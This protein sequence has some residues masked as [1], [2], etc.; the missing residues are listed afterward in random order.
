MK[1]GLV[2]VVAVWL[3]VPGAAFAGGPSERGL[4]PPAPVEGPSLPARDL[5]APAL[6]AV[7]AAAIPAAVA[8]PAVPTLEQLGEAI[9]G[10]TPLQGLPEVRAR[11][12]RL[13][14]LRSTDFDHAA[15]EPALRELAQALW[16]EAAPIT[17]RLFPVDRTGPV[18]ALKVEAGGS[19]YYVHGVAHAPSLNLPS[20]RRSEV[21][22]LVSEARRREEPL[23]SEL[24]LPAAYSFDYGTEVVD[25]G[26][27]VSERPAFKDVIVAAVQRAWLG[28]KWAAVAAPA[29][30]V[31][32][33]PSS[34]GAW[35]AL[36]GGAAAAYLIHRSFAPA[37]RAA[38]L[39]RSLVAAP[40]RAAGFR[41]AWFMLRRGGE[42]ALH[43]RRWA[44]AAY[45][46][47]LDLDALRRV[48]LPV[49]TPGAR[50]KRR[51]AALA[52][53]AGRVAVP[54]KAVHVLAGFQHM[55]EVAAHLAHDQ[56]PAASG[57]KERP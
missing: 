1:R 19:T 24:N 55:D 50:N 17:P 35:V 25:D 30:L 23:V 12:A 40:A 14:A 18:P 20:R 48:Q 53:A 2:R 44:A 11:L 38:Y 28:A 51:A 56:S 13:G 5:A 10:T 49:A 29:A 22:A 57:P 33:S 15:D 26:P 47:T 41:G 37:L 43:A 9:Q 34:I 42:T 6:P 54:G 7:D 32:A 36:G 27:S 31:A 21:R 4:A 39:W 3:L 46:P 52:Q 16:Y 45:A 8:V